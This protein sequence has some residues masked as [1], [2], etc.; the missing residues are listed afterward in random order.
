MKGFPTAAERYLERILIE[1]ARPLLLSF[2]RA[3]QLR[4]VSGDSQ[5]FGYDGDPGHLIQ[6]LRD[7]FVGSAPDEVLDFPFVE[8]GHGQVAHVHRIPDGELNHV[9]L[10]DAAEDHA[11]SQSHQQLGN[12]A[13]LASIEKSKVLARLRLVRSEL[14]LQRSRLEEANSLKNALIATLSHEF[15]TPLTSI[16]GYLH[17]LERG[18]NNDS[19]STQ[20]L[21]ALR[22]NATWLFALAE[23]LLEY[24]RAES[25]GGLLNPGV[26]DLSHLRDDLDAMFRP[27]AEDKQ[28]EFSISCIG[29]TEVA[30]EVDEVKVRQVAINLLSN[31]VRYTQRGEIRATMGWHGDE[32][33]LEVRDTG[34]G[35]APELRER[36]FQAFNRGGQQG[37]KGAGLGL[38]I[39]K[40]LVEQMQ[41]NIELKSDDSG[42]CFTISLP[43]LAAATAEV[44]VNA[45]SDSATGAVLQQRS[46]IV[47]DDDP[48]VA[49]LLEVLLGDRGFDV[50]LY[51]DANAAVEA[52]LRELPDVLLVD[53]EL[54][55]VSGNAATFQ[56]RA[57]GYL[58]RIVTLSASATQEARRAAL[59]AGADHY[60]SKP[61]NLDQFERV[62][63]RV[64][65]PRV[66]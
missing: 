13:G 47:L 51:A 60:L 32:L 57:Q 49:A 17:L 46:A 24:G 20:A 64:A 31:A 33:R 65:R 36:V 4:E 23:N 45:G 12:E 40:R 14:E 21:R 59:A 10:L 8:L 41:G 48:D 34:I 58:G 55:G 35:I 2:D 15:R 18:S 53:V 27:L 50:S 5:R 61:L 28:L 1:R 3:W 43:A 11:R 42:S 25:S 30:A 39:V 16:F 56:L 22:R 44:T 54:P 62:M 9:L 63:Q 37:S 19:M 7:L 26:V 29:A 6:N 52:T 66:S 38:S